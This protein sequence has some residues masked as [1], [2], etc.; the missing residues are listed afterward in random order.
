MPETTSSPGDLKRSGRIAALDLA[1]GFAVT[2]MIL[3]HG[4]KGLLTFD[5]IPSWGLVPIHLI[6]KFSSSLFIIVF[7]A[8][9]GAAFLP[10]VHTDQ[11]PEKR[12]KLWVRG[13]KVFFW[14]KVLTI[15]EM[16]HLYSAQDILKTLTYQAFPVYVEILG[17]Y[18]IA[19]LWIPAIL[20]LWARFSVWS[21]T[22]FIV[23]LAFAAQWLYYNFHFW[24]SE[25]LKAI[26]VEHEKHYAWGQL[27]R[28]P[29][30]LLGVL[31]GEQIAKAYWIPE[32]RWKI[33]LGFVVI[34]GVL[35]TAL[36]A[37]ETAPLQVTLRE[38]ALNE[39]KHPPEAYFMLFS[40]CGAS[41]LLGIAI[42]GG[43]R[44]ARWLR[45][46]TIIGQDALQ[47]FIFHIFVVF[48]FYR[49]LFGYFRS[50]DYVFAV[51]L[52]VALIAMTAIWIK[53]TQWVRANS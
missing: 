19:L 38:I 23:A 44:L 31:F 7:G 18:S 15:V 34:A 22:I 28:G 52:T 16:A 47:S 24:G 49:Y 29:L 21:R 45:P 40:L 43:E 4:I 25:E 48:V 17:F 41:A 26:L 36:L 13:L 33:G 2:L 11:W 9:L 14:Y 50:V 30:A 46:I 27:S 39:G 6:T 35:F 32:R 1:R 12:R 37:A 51:Q 10:Y 8:A 53:L 5:Q 3:S 42:V 20:P